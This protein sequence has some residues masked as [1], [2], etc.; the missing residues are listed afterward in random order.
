MLITHTPPRYHLDLPAG[1][2]CDFLL[3]EVWKVRP[4]LHVFG[5][6]HAGYGQ[7]SVFWDEAQKVYERLC[8]RREKGV[9]RDMVA[10][11]AWFDLVKLALYGVLGVLW[12]RVWGGDGSDSLMVN[13]ALMYR[14]SG[15]LGNNPQVVEI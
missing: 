15:K 3:K 1:L 14:S 8:A 2:G 13:S 7:E 5:H 10:I 4:R 11:R 12:T 6:V 9:L